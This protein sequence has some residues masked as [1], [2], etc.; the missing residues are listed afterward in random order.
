[1]YACVYA[2]MHVVK[3]CKSHKVQSSHASHT[4]CS[5]VKSCE[6]ARVSAETVSSGSVV[7]AGVDREDR[8][9]VEKVA[10]VRR[11]PWSEVCEDCVT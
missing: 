6:S 11:V 8:I 10:C 9:V 2:C 5:Q 4:S 7:A 3:S 1:M